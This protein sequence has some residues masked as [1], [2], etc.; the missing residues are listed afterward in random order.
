MQELQTLGLHNGKDWLVNQKTKDALLSGQLTPF[1]QLKNLKIDGAEGVNLDAKLSLRQNDTG[2]TKLAIHPI[3]KHPAGHPL[4]S[5]EDEMY[6]NLDGV[7]ARKEEAWGMIAQRGAAPYRFIPDNPPSPY[8]ELEKPDGRK[9]RIWGMDVSRA[10]TESGFKVGDSVQIKLAGLETTPSQ[11]NPQR[12][13]WTVESLTQEKT[14][15]R[16]AL[17]EFDQ[18]TNSTVR[19]DDRQFL[20]PDQINGVDLSPR[21]KERLRR[22]EDVELKEGSR[23]QVSPAS[24]GSFRSNRRLLLA[25]F[26]IDGGISYAIYKGV[27]ALIENG[28][29]LDQKDPDYSKGYVDALKKVQ[30]DLEQK[31]ARFPNDGQI[32]RDLDLVREEA[33]RVSEIPVTKYDS[34]KSRVN[35]PELENNAEQ[36]EIQQEKERSDRYDRVSH[37]D[38]MGHN[39]DTGLDDPE[40]TP[41]LKR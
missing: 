8:V 31:Q 11:D 33:L 20:L 2:E 5:K 3:Y 10:V 9:D 14:Q 4:L 25:S 40:E 18:Q 21:E 28:K 7:Y 38:D 16:T 35:D 34:I 12:L 37:E 32:A 1:V 6:M 23:L 36:R 41:R 17:Y 13:K 29:K 26:I 27:N 19:T 30:Q 24:E 39:P 15:D 22:G